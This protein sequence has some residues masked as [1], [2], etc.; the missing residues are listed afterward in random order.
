MSPLPTLRLVLAGTLVLST[1][2]GCGLFD[3]EAETGWQQVATAIEGVVDFRT[4]QPEMIAPSHTENPVF[5]EVQPPVGGPH[6][7]QWQDCNGAVYPEPVIDVHAVHSMEHGAVWVTYRPDLAP[8][9]VELLAARVRD[10]EKIFMS[11]YPGL[12]PPISLQAWGYQ[13][14]VDD[15]SDDRIDEFIR[16]LR[17][18][19]SL[20]G[21]GIP[22]HGGVTTTVP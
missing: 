22:C 17:V 13:L 15:A 3:D 14:K 6:H 16:A 18:N 19:A 5:Y 21:P 1:V 8:D 2:G 11:P 9:Q 20:E 12:D 7:P 4:E 10:T